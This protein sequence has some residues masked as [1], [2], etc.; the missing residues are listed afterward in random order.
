M[1]PDSRL[2]IEKSPCAALDVAEM[3][4]K[5]NRNTRTEAPRDRH[6]RLSPA[7]VAKMGHARSVLRL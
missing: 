4:M 5:T 2:S 3:A 6:A 1:R 7:D